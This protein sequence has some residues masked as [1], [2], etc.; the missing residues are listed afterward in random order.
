MVGPKNEIIRNL[1]T[2][3]NVRISQEGMNNGNS[4]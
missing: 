1:K 2:V 3:E 4:N